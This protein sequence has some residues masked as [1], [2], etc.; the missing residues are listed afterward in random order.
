MIGAHIQEHEIAVFAVPAH[1]PIL[2]HETQSILFDFLLLVGKTEGLRFGRAGIMILAQRMPLPS[3][4]HNYA[5]KMRMAFKNDAE[6]IPY[7]TLVPIG[8]RPEIADRR[9][10]QVGLDQRNFD[11][12]I[13]VA[14]ER[15]QMIDDGK[16]TVGKPL[17]ARTLTL[18]DGGQVEQQ[19]IRRSCL[20]F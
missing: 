18:V 3:R 20:H 8:R 10:R 7:F 11:A 17:A 4:R 12:D 9:E 19:C 6:H 13:F 1:A 15:Q 2:R 14:V 5:P 16:L